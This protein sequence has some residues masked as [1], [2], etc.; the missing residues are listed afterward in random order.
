MQ[1]LIGKSSL[2]AKTTQDCPLHKGN[3]LEWICLEKN[4]EKRIFCQFCV[5]Q[6]HKNTHQDFT[7]ISQM[8]LDPLIAFQKLDKVDSELEAMQP[9]SQLSF[10]TRMQD[11]IKKE[12]EKLGIL[13]S[14]LSLGLTSKFEQ[15][16]K[17]FHD[18]VEVFLKSKENEIEYIETNRKDYIEFVKNY[19]PNVDFQSTEQLKEGINIILSK[20]FGDEELIKNLKITQQAIPVVKPNEKYQFLLNNREISSLKWRV[21][22]DKEL[23]I[24]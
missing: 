1:N 19:F 11:F 22:M 7:H 8:L 9:S 4:C 3:K 23:C 6:E 24:I 2:E 16:R 10:R 21:F 15:I 20:Y 17:S 13:L 18:D 12:E 5:I 14:S